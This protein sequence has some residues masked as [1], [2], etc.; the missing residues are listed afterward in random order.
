MKRIPRWVALVAIFTAGLVAFSPAFAMDLMERVITTQTTLIRHEATEYQRKVA[1]YNARKYVADQ[2][3][4]Q[5]HVIAAKRKASAPSK[6]KAPAVTK[7]QQKKQ[8]ADDLAEA[9]KAVK[10][11]A[12]RYLAVNTPPD[13]KRE[14]GVKH[15]VMLWDTQS[16]SLVGNN[17]YDIPTPPPLGAKAKFDTYSAQYVGGGNTALQ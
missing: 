16:E 15:D 11:A 9:T 5:Q 7:E 8:D 3:K 4:A 10:K 2:I 12:P 17:V 1:E 13:A 6:G 14:P